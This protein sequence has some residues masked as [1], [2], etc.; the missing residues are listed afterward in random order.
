[1][2][3]FLLLSKQFTKKARLLWIIGM[4]LAALA[5]WYTL[6]R[7]FNMTAAATPG[8]LTALAA[9]GSTAHVYLLFN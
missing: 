3:I 9:S 6:K 4:P 5:L 1:M 8:W 2:I 7:L